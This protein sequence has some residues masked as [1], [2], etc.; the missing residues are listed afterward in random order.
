ME[1]SVVGSDCMGR[2]QTAAMRRHFHRWP[3]VRAVCAAAGKLAAHLCARRLPAWAF[4]LLAAGAAGA[5]GEAADSASSAPARADFTRGLIELKRQATARGTPDETTKTNLKFDF[6]P[7]QGAVAL[8]RLELPFPDGARQGSC[9]LIH[10]A[11]GCLSSAVECAATTDSRSGLRVTG[12]V[13]VQSR[14]APD[15][16]AGLSSRALRY[17]AWRAARMA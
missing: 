5:A 17:S 7:S 4:A 3:E 6:F 8:L 10:A 9:R 11:S 2:G 13:R 15:Q 14:V 16:R 12:P 1:R